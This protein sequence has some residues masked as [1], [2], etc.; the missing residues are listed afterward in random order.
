MYQNRIKNF[1]PG[2]FM[3]SVTFFALPFIYG[4]NAF[5]QNVTSTTVTLSWTAPGDNDDIGT[6]SEYDIRYSLSLINESNWSSAIQTSGEPNPQT[7]G[8][9]ETFIVEN[10]EPN[11]TY[12]FALKSAD[13]IPNWSDI[14]NVISRTT[15]EETTAPSAIANLTLNNATLSSIILHWTAPGDDG[16][17]GQASEYDIRYSTSLINAANWDAAAQV[18]NETAPKQ[19]GFAESFIVDGLASGTIYYFAIKTADDVP[20][21]SGISNVP[22]LATESESTAPSVIAG[23]TVDNITG[24]SARL[25]W[26][27]PGDDGNSGT[28]ALYDIRYSTA[29]LSNET[30]WNNATQAAGEPTP[31]VAGTAQSFTVT[32]LD[33]ETVYYFAIKTADEV[34]NW[35]GMSN[36]V[37][38]TTADDVPPAAVDDLAAVIDLL[39]KYNFV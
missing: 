2:L 31:L 28:A 32:G 39:L 9:A 17:S 18:A 34:P 27:A 37:N 24:N 11:T 12:Y 7:A 8:S 14:S 13:E 26:A 23:L 25:N 15:L 36:V 16:A 33:I 3:L 38:S 29:P 10:L 5:A 1:L 19:T 22:S 20:N 6:A 21:W 30:D 35:S 4:G